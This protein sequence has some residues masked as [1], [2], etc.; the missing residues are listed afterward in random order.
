MYI[1]TKTYTHT[2]THKDNTFVTYITYMSV[3]APACTRTH[4]CALPL[5]PS[6]SIRFL[7]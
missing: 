4:P 3:C 5:T 1:H 6:H 2:Y 7:L